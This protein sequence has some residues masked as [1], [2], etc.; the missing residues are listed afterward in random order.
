MTT[1]SS[2]NLKPERRP[3]QNATKV[4]VKDQSQMSRP[5]STHK[6]NVKTTL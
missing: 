3:S 4:K 5:T 6:S 2:H 1:K